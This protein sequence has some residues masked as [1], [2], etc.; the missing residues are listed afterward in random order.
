MMFVTVVQS[1]TWQV[2]D[3]KS[4]WIA[5]SGLLKFLACTENAAFALQLL[6]GLRGE[7]AA[8]KLLPALSPLRKVG[9]VHGKEGSNVT[10][11]TLSRC[12][13]DGLPHP[14]RAEECICVLNHKHLG[15]RRSSSVGPCGCALEHHWALPSRRFCCFCLHRVPF[16]LS[17]MVFK[18]SGLFVEIKAVHFFIVYTLYESD[19][20]PKSLR[21]IWICIYSN[22]RHLA[23]LL[24][25]MSWV[26]ED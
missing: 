13:A 14:F 12:S 15:G 26:Y 20:P 4:L 22:L 6:K 25:K 21:F 24:R 2:C 17:V 16:V 18:V 11:L 10:C 5:A 19:I 1:N 7:W 3:S 8:L 23:F 9:Q